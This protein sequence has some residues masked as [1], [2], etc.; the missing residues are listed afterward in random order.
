MRDGYHH[1]MNEIFIASE[2]SRCYSDEHCF[3]FH[4]PT[5]VRHFKNRALCVGYPDGQAN[6]VTF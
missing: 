1:K 6:Y 3:D 5:Q 2:A 4:A